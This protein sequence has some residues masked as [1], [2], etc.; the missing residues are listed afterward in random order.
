MATNRLLRAKANIP[1]FGGECA[2]EFRQSGVIVRPYA[3]P[4][5]RHSW[6]WDYLLSMCQCGSC[7]PQPDIE[8]H[9]DIV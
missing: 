9:I 1:E 8:M 5:V 3:H 6:T 4:G 2:V 7:K